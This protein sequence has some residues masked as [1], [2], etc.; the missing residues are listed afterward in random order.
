V[1]FYGFQWKDAPDEY[2]PHETLYYRFVGWSK[3]GVLNKIFTK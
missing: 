2:G 1:S 3:L